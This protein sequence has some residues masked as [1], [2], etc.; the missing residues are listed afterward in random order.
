MIK[1]IKNITIIILLIYI[2]FWI[3]INVT[4]S[5]DLEN[6]LFDYF[7]D[8][9]GLIAL[10]GSIGGFLT[11]KLWGGIKSSIGRALF[12]ISTGLLFQFLGQICYAIYYYAYGIENPY[13]SFGEIFYFTSIPIYIYSIWQLA[14]AAGI[15]YSLK[16]PLN[17][18]IS[19]VIP[20]LMIG[21]SYWLFLTDYSVDFESTKGIITTLLDFGYP[22]GQAIYVSIA[23]IAYIFSKKMLGGL[24]REYVIGILIAFIFQYFADTMFLYNTISETW[25]PGGFDDLMFLL[26]Y[27]ITGYSVIKFAVAYKSIKSKSR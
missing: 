2:T 18:F 3:S 7:T 23:I 6:K 19:L 22:L 24:M 27:F 8:S 13:P 14:G 21:Y 1:T 15:S 25:R 12:G 9:Y 5:N 10:A 20:L 11:S 17:K 26:A 4:L 16:T